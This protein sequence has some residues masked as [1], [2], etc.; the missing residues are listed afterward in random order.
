MTFKYSVDNCYLNR[1]RG[2]GILIVDDDEISAGL[3]KEYLSL[4]GHNVLSLNEG[5]KCIS[6]CIKNKFDIIFLD[7]HI[8]DIDGVELADCL[9]DVLK[10]KSRIFA[11]TGDSSPMAIKK[12]KEIGM[13]G[14]LI[15]PL[16]FSKI[17][18]IISDIENQNKKKISSNI[19]FF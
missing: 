18:N 5:V 6:E 13:D 4:L 11:Y 2:L 14:V 9:K 10:T 15:K 12:F 7:Y 8:K 19:I 17:N 3:F 1:N 16:D